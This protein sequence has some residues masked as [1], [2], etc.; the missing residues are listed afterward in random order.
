MAVVNRAISKY[1][2]NKRGS[3]DQGFGIL[4]AS[5]ALTTLGVTLAYA[6]PLFLYSRINNTT[7]EVRTGA[8]MVAQRALDNVRGQ[9]FGTPVNA[10]VAVPIITTI[11]AADAFALGRQYTATLSHCKPD[12][13]CTIT[14]KTLEVQVNYNG[15]PIYEMDA[16]FTN[17]R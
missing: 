16:G 9:P 10:T 5:I 6:M 17:F 12:D 11:A 4:E 7:S 14:Y 1:K 3:A 15:A 8:M 2:S 13:P